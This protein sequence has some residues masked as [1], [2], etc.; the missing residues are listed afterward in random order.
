MATK[1]VTTPAGIARHP[2]LNRPDTKFS[3]KNKPDGDYKVILEMSSEEAE[4]FIK[5]IESMFADF[6]AAKKAETRKDKL[7]IAPP[8][9]TENDGTVQFK[10]KVYATWPPDKDGKIQSRAPKLF[11]KDGGSTDNIAS[12]TKMQIA[13]EPYFW[14]AP[15]KP[16]GTKG[17]GITLQPKAVMIHDL[18]A[19]GNGGTA[20]AYGFDVSEAKDSEAKTG[21]DDQE[22]PW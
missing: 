20:E 7:T 21:T 14:P 22:I 4:P 16:M 3:D 13:V 8:P 2:H 6:L 12:G 5:Q 10:L 1:T 17:C 18:V 19:W 15:G 9:W 11:A